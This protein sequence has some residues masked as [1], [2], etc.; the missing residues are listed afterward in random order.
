MK[1]NQE[2]KGRSEAFASFQEILAAGAA[3]S[4][5]D[6]KADVKKILEASGGKLDA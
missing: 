2:Q 6:M 5:P 1:K 3:D 4:I